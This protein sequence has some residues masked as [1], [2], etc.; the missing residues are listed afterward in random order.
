[1]SSD[2][3]DIPLSK[4]TKA[5]S[6]KLLKVD[7]SKGERRNGEKIRR[8]R[9]DYDDEDIPKARSSKKV[10]KEGNGQVGKK[11]K[12]RYDSE[13][14]ENEDDE[15]HLRKRDRDEYDDDDEDE[16]NDEYADSNSGRKKKNKKKKKEGTSEGRSSDALKIVNKANNSKDSRKEEKK[17][18]I[19]S[20]KQL[21]KLD[22]TE[23][24]AHAMQSFLWWDAQEPPEGCQWS[25]MEHAGVSFPEPYVPHGIKMKY[26][27]KDVDL[28]PVEEEAYVLSSR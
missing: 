15:V 4:M 8:E 21:K 1:M 3:D 7:N 20:D 23:R 19:N 13:K 16:D 5:P 17:I 9:D 27:G 22:K 10:H 25:S 2:D 26:D 28:N 24:I 18:P 11:R 12:I 6:S 14:E